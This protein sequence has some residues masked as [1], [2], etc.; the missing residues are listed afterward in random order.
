MPSQK[1]TIPISEKIY[2]RQQVCLHWISAA[3]ILWAS[4]TGFIVASLPIND[5]YRQFIDMFNPQITTVLMPLFLWRL[6]IAIGR[7]VSGPAISRRGVQ[8]KAAHYAHIGLYLLVI[9]VLST[10]ALMMTHGVHLLGIIPLPQLIHSPSVL[11]AIFAAHR[12]LCMLL[13]GL[14][15]LHIAAVAKHS[16][17]GTPVLHRMLR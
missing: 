17:A 3:V 13:A 2:T 15:V 1:V 4:V 12:L 9:S 11:S 7:G 16:L 14:I 5:P 8:A 10:G 6:L